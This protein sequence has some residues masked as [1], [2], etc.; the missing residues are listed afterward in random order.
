[1]VT[2]VDC[3]NRLLLMG[4]NGAEKAKTLVVG[5]PSLDKD[6]FIKNFE[7]TIRLL[8]GLLSGYQLTGDERRLRLAGD[9]GARL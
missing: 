7:V 2:P 9:L 8:G 4:L 5:K 1:M 6:I 3:L